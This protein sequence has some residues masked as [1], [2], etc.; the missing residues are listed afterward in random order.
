MKI[1]LLLS[2][3]TAF[4]ATL[5]SQTDHHY[6]YHENTPYLTWGDYH[7]QN[8]LRG[9]RSLMTDLHSQDPELYKTLRP[10]YQSLRKRQQEA[11]IILG[12]FSGVGAS[13][14]V[15]GFVKNNNNIPTQNNPSPKLDYG[16]I[17]GGTIVML[18]APIIYVT[19]AVRP[20]DILDFTNHFNR[21][22]KGEKI[23]ISMRPEVQ[24]INGA[25]AGLSLRFVF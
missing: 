4:S 9:L 12:V 18:A 11:G 10:E 8:S 21:H 24:F 15:A 23:Q 7:Y 17:V 6:I 22:T 2:L 20:N 14:T 13:L 3:M 5:F 1:K 19:K 25:S 16:L